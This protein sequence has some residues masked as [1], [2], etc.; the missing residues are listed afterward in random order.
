MPGV[1]ISG[2]AS[3]DT[4]DLTDLASASA[5]LNSG[6]NV[7]TISAGG[8]TY[9]LRLA[10]NFATQSASAVSDGGS[11]TDIMVAC[12]AAG[13]LIR[14]PGGEVPVE[15]LQPGQLVTTLDG[16]AAP[17]RWV[18]H[19]R[20]ACDRH[21][22]PW[23]V[24][25][26]RVAAGAFAP[27]QPRRDLFLS[28]DHAVF[29]GGVLIPARYL[30]NGRT[31]ARVPVAAIE[32]LHVEL[33]RHDVLLA[34]GL[35]AESFLDTGNRCAFANGGTVTSLHPDFAPRIWQ[36]E[37]CADLVLG[38]PRLAEARRRLLARAAALGHRITSHP[39]LA[40]VADGRR[41]AVTAEGAAWRARL[42]AGVATVRL[43]SRV[44][45]PA[46]TDPDAN[47]TR[48]LGVA[49]SRLALDGHAIPLDSPALAAG[50][51]APEPDW[52]WTDGAATIAVGGAREIGFAV[53]IRGRYWQALRA[54][55]AA[56]PALFDLV[57]RSIQE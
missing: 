42:P 20:V 16:A 3:G 52:R 36:A 28:P 12:F 41:L 31:V 10:G 29:T 50:W 21:P 25:P 2:L 22:R 18:G 53:A 37:G 11:G 5:S 46:E 39:A 48:A 44:W 47:D 30:V 23:D 51:H 43:R 27:G 1:T 33:D 17:V 49:V 6:T 14:V 4:I 9:S 34:E 56:T 24:W 32:Y 26:I 15:S 19:R 54:G 7:L 55:Q 35:P 40:M 13:T 38:G 57:C 8:S 45:I